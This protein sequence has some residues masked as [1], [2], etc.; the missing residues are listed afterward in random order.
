[1]KSAVK[2]FKILEDT[3]ISGKKYQNFNLIKIWNMLHFEDAFWFPM[4]LSKH[5]E[6]KI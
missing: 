1:M 3:N 4:D 5:V 6:I 2:L